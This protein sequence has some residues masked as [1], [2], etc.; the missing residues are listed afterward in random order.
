MFNALSYLGQAAVY[1]ALAA[2]LGY[3]SDSPA[4]VH[5]PADEAL[6]KLS[7]IHGGRKESC[8]TRTPEE[9]ERLAP[10]MRRAVVCSRERLPVVV[11]LKLDGHDLYRAV[12]PPTGLF[13]DGPSQAYARFPVAPGPHELGMKL[14][15]TARIEGWDYGREE[16]IDLKPLQN[17][18]ID[19]RA[20]TG[21]FLIK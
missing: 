6:I 9:L 17:L 11:E 20:E 14:R 19:F 7:L 12:L 16:D 2:L 15:D 5:F 13:G 18:A 10:N 4:Y 1:S 21:G 8:R 3:F